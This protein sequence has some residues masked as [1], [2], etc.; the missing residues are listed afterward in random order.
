MSKRD[1]SNVLGGLDWMIF[2][3][4]L[5]L[6]GVGWLMIY[7][8]GYDE[9]SQ[10][11]FF[12]LTTNIGK[13]TFFIAVSLVVLLFTWII[14]WKFWR[15]FAYLIYALGLLKL[16]GVLLFG[17]TVKGAKSW[18]SIGGFTYQPSEFAKFATCVAL[19]TFLSTYSTN[20]KDR[21]A[22]FTAGALVLVPMFL[23]LLQPDAG[24]ALVFLSFLFMLYRAGLSANFYIVGFVTATLFI[25]GLV[26]PP[27]IVVTGLLQLVALFLIFNFKQKRYPLIGLLLLTIA[28]ILGI[29]YNYIL[30][31][32]IVNFI[33]LVGVLYLLYRNRKGRLVSQVSALLVIGSVVTFSASYFFN[34]ILERHQQDRINVWLR[35]SICD[36]QGALYNVLQSK[37]SIGSGGFR[38][39][40]FLQ[41]NMT[42]LNYVPEQST[43]FIFCTIGEEQGFIGSLSIIA[44]FLLL[45]LRIVSIAERQRSE[46]S[47]FYAY[48]VAG[49]LFIHVF[50]NIGMTMGL[51]PIIGIPLPFI[52]YGGSSI[53]G[54]TLMI[55][56]LLRLDSKRLL[57]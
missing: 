51:V 50:V 18:Y 32:F 3:L 9:D 22:L 27:V 23:I 29:N 43:D 15:T 48:G 54:F 5:S 10:M 33:G 41:G 1:E 19:A 14:D 42:K 30:P 35:P 57:V 49:I 13:Q 44:L 40:G 20:I 24:S 4:Y 2:S 17:I 34:N 6:V 21:N 38:G 12:N 36:P 31:V 39:K 55:G 37:M 7:T 56:V 28:S 25:L 11:G 45:I 53:L 16:V 26:F 8:V 52:S 46:F 47:R